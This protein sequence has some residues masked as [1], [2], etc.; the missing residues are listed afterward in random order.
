VI[1][2]SFKIYTNVGK[3]EPA[4]RNNLDRF[5]FGYRRARDPHVKIAKGSNLTHIRIIKGYKADANPSRLGKKCYMNL[6]IKQKLKVTQG[7]LM[8][9]LDLAKI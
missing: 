4:T 2:S 5:G 7:N 6:N 9:L 1:L 8:N 3:L